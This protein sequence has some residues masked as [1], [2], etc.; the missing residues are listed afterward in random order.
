MVGSWV[1]RGELKYYLMSRT[2][3]ITSLVRCHYHIQTLLHADN[4]LFQKH[5][6]YLFLI[7]AVSSN[8]HTRCYACAGFAAHLPRK[9][10]IKL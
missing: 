10:V 3:Q 6:R 9:I 5:V 2:R 1:S 8:G 7:F 4:R